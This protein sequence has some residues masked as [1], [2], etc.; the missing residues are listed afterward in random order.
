MDPRE[1]DQSIKD[2]KQLLYET[3]APANAPVRA[4]SKPFSAYLQETPAA[5]LAPWVKASIWAAGAVVALLLAGAA[6]KSSPPKSTPKARRT[7]AALAPERS[8]AM[9]I[10]PVARSA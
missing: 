9:G 5:P 6:T 7:K 8:P 2:R 1:Q 3:D 4:P 10:P